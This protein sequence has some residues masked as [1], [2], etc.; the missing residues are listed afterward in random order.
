MGRVETGRGWI[1]LGCK[2]DGIAGTFGSALWQL[3]TLFSHGKCARSPQ[4]TCTFPV[5]GIAGAT[6]SGEPVT[7]AERGDRNPAPCRIGAD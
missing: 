4:V 6:V 1:M 2:K 7:F 3:T 5:L